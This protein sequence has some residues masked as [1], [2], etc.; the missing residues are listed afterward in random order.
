MSSSSKVPSSKKAHKKY[1]NN[2]QDLDYGQYLSNS[3]KTKASE[4]ETDIQ[5]EINN[6]SVTPCI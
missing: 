3:C 1:A 6:S 5:N 4:G 2:Y